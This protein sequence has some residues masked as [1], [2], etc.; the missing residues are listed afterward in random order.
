MKVVTDVLAVR[1]S[2][3]LIIVMVASIMAPVCAAEAVGENTVVVSSFTDRMGSVNITAGKDEGIQV[4]TK[5][6]IIKDGKKIAD[7]VVVQVNWGISRVD[8]SNLLEGYEVEPGDSAP[9]SSTP[10][11]RKSNRTSKILKV[12]G[13]AAAVYLLA[14]MGGSDGGSD[15]GQITLTAFKETIGE[16]IRVTINANVK[17]KDGDPAEDGTEVTFSTTAGDLQ[18]TTRT[19]A[20]GKATTYLQPGVEEPEEATVTAKALGA[21]ATIDVSFISSIELEADPESIQVIGSGGTVTQTT[22]TATCT[23]AAG[24]PATSGEV[25]FSASIG[26]ITDTADIGA[27]GIAT[28]TFSSDVIGTATITA[29]WSNSSATTEVDVTAGPPFSIQVTSS[30]SS[31]QIDGNSSAVITATIRDIA[32]NPVTDGTVV[33]FSVLPDGLGGGNGTITPQDITS[34]GVAT[35]SLFTQ[36]A[37]GNDSLPGTAT[38]VVEVLIANQPSD[39]PLPAMDLQNDSKKVQFVSVEPESINLSANPMNIRGWDQTGNTSTITAVVSAAGGTPVPDGTDIYFSATHGQITP[40]GTTSGGVA[41]ATLTGDASGDGTWDGLV[42]VTATAG[43]ASGGVVVTFSGPAYEPN[44]S[45]DI[46]PSTLATVNGQATVSVVVHDENDHAVVNGT[47]VTPYPSQG[48]ISPPV[49]STTGGLVTFTLKT[50]T[51]SE[52][53]TPAGDYTVQLQIDTGNGPV[54]LTVDFTVS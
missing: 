24:N 13:I 8:I 3:I 12:L 42:D 11:V 4:G 27:G 21:T 53:P 18:Y 37:G 14:N 44:C 7:Y 45:A 25:E 43:T 35:A 34:N 20:G 1:L 51:D 9:V 41:T 38:V 31:L 40:M 28:A 15:D 30:S 23:D 52:N 54:V 50:S 48:T 39:V 16:D 2:V 32:G 19:T 5:G 46:S 49:G 26:D 17:D 29:E 33:D 10:V 36:D 22:I 47:H 6:V